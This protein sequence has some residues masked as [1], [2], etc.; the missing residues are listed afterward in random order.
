MMGF[1]S[2]EEWERFN[3]NFSVFVESYA[4]LEALRDKMFTRGGIGNQVDRVIFGLGRVCSEDF[5]Q[6]IIL[7]GN[8]LGIGA[9]QMVRGMYERQVTAAYLSNHPDEVGAFLNY[10][11]VHKRKELNHLKEAYRGN[12]AGLERLIPR[13]RQEEIEQEF[14]DVEAE[15]TETMCEPCNKT[16]I[17]MSWSKHQTPAL[18]RKGTQDLHLLY[19]YQY[20]RPTLYSHSTVSSLL[21]RMV[22]DE[23]GNISFEAEGQRKRVAEALVGAHNLL[24]N[25]FDLQNKH[26]NLGLQENIDECFEDYKR[27]WAPSGSPPG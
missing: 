6:A 26:F 14:R 20:F 18:A 9:L 10:H 27:C 23:D 19:Y 3:T 16:R 4:A 1:G 17:M 21:A 24:L 15:F 13:E 5:Q 7:C 12:A 22:Q 25:V 2:E 8:G 11:Y